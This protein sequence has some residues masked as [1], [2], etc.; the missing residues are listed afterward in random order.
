MVNMLVGTKLLDVEVIKLLTIISNDDSGKSKTTYHVP[1]YE[2][3][4][5]IFFGLD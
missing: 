1:P 5:V 3:L 4:G 2:L